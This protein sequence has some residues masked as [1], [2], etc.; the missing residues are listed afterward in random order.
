MM[1]KWLAP[2]Q[3]EIRTEAFDRTERWLR[4]ARDEGGVDA[5]VIVTFQNR[6]LPPGRRDAR[7]DVEVRKG[8]AFHRGIL[9]S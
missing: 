6:R 8:R 1:R 3:L 4:H 2:Q 7:V 5:P 9:G